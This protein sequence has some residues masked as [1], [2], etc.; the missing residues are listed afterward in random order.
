[1]THFVLMLPAIAG[2][3]IILI[4]V[5]LWQRE[6]SHL[7]RREWFVA[8]GPI[9]FAAP[10]ATFGTEHLVIPH[11]I[12][13]LVPA[14]LPARLLIAYFVGVALI[15]ASLAFTF[16]Q[17]V[18]LAA[19]LTALMFGLFVCLLHLPNVAATHWTN[20]QFWLLVARDSSFGMGAFTLFLA[21]SG[22]EKV[23]THHKT[24]LRIARIWIALA[25]LFFGIQQLLHP[26]CSPGV[27]GPRA[28]PSW[29]PAPLP[30]GYLCG[31]V[32]LVCGALMLTKR[33][34]RSASAGVAALMTVLTLFLYLPDSFFLPPSSELLA[35]NYIFDTLLFGG[36]TLLLARA[37][38]ARNSATSNEY[39][40]A[41][42]R[43][44]T[45]AA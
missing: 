31:V 39:S 11:Q 20:R 7:P 29:V 16:K 36:A 28:T 25:V 14:W 6:L 15:A 8:L 43:S 21:A 24:S 18:P 19:G 45:S 32:L 40:S 9:L 10:L 26:E 38:P 35:A 44:T 2:A 30:L 12:A 34:A 13:Q 42:P 17:Q 33:F 5:A 1:M 4:G 3:V 37:L 22:S 27:P 23:Q 41:S